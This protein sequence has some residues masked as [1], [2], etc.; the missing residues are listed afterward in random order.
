MPRKSALT[1]EALT[2]L[3][4]DRL[5]RLVLEEAGR[6][7]PFKKV[8]S[9]ALAGARGP[10]AVAAIIDRRLTALERAKGFITW[11]KRKAFV[12]DLNAALVTII[13][14]LGISDATAAVDRVLRFLAGA[15]G[16][17]ERVDD[18]SGQVQGVY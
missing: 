8:V 11:E 1:P 7:A 12:A 10:D 16:V 4:A 9:A 2:A 15:G 13:D 17:F 14:E 18:S 6:N 3:G 5:A